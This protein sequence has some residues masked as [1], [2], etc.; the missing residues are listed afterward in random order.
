MNTL[1]KLYVPRKSLVAWRKALSKETARMNKIAYT[2]AVKMQ[3]LSIHNR[4]SS[5]E[6][7]SLEFKHFYD[8]PN[9]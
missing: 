7:R 2:N 5:E 1:H 6:A 3:Q 9:K 4:K 8:T